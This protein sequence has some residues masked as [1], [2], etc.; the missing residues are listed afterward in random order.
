MAR[1]EIEGDWVKGWPDRKRLGLVE[2]KD[3]HERVIFAQTPFVDLEGLITPTDLSYIWAQLEMPEPVHPDD[4]VFSI[5]GEVERPLQ[6]TLEELQKFPGRTVRAVI[7]CAGNDTDFFNY[8]RDGGPKPS[9]SKIG[10]LSNLMEK[11]REESSGSGS[12]DVTLSSSGYTGLVSTGEFTGVP[13]ATVLEKAGLRPNAVSV[14]TEGFDQGRP[15]PTIQYL[16]AGRTDIEVVDPGIINYDKGLPLEKALHPDTILAW[17]Q[18]GEYLQ[19]VHGAP[20]RLV[21]PGWSGNWWVKWLQ[22]IEVMDHMPECYYQTHYFI[23]ADSPEAPNKEML[24]ALGV[25]S[26]ITTPRDEDSP[27]S[28]GSHTIRGLAW[29]GCGMITRVEVSVDNGKTWHE[30]HLEE[31]REKWLWA[32]WFY[33]WDVNQPGQYSIMVRATDEDGRTQPQIKWNFQRKHFDGIVPVEV[34]V[35]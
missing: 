25:K 7:E 21:V 16:A 17:A 1:R 10:D 11:T 6:L 4:W 26:V 28:C 14:R 18:N 32:R 9:R 3:E 30:A 24:T 19:H 8:L 27:L 12:D 15:D 5:G 34:D 20:V 13:L 2:G 22:K 23:Y 33:L 29:S 31:P 35:E